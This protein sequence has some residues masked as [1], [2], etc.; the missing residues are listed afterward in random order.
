MSPWTS[1]IVC[2]AGL[3]IPLA[4]FFASPRRGTGKR[5]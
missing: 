2:A 5:R 3:I 1:L 4:L